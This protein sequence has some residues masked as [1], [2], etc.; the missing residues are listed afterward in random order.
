MSI[1]PNSSTEKKW[2]TGFPE[3]KRF[4]VLEIEFLTGLREAEPVENSPPQ[5]IECELHNRPGGITRKKWRSRR[6]FFSA[7]SMG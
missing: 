3:P 1:K 2:R 6:T 5:G 4:R 7:F